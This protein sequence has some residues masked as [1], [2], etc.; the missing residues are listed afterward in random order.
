MKYAFS[1]HVK[2]N[3]YLVSIMIID[4]PQLYAGL[5]DRNPRP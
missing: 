2:A 3:A 5:K 1:T 4:P